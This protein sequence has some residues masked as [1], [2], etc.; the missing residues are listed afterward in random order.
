MT[1]WIFVNL[2]TLLCFLAWTKIGSDIYGL[3]V[4]SLKQSSEEPKTPT[5]MKFGSV[6]WRPKV[7]SM[8]FSVTG[9]SKNLNTRFLVE[10]EGALILR[11]KL[12]KLS[13][14]LA[15]NPIEYH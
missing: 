15:T 7:V 3:L 9:P 11:P 10:V 5:L 6:S 8:A 4:L 2:T 1:V 14:D 13:P 12:L